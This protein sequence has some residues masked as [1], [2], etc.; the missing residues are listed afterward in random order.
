MLY[1]LGDY[2]DGLGFGDGLGL[3]VEITTDETLL[4]ATGHLTPEIFS[5]A[6]SQGSPPVGTCRFGSYLSQRTGECKPWWPWAVGIGVVLVA[7]G[8]FGV[9][10]KKR[11]ST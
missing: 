10:K 3:D 9:F 6:A 4:D 1:L 11:R 2:G 5:A 7:A 8:G